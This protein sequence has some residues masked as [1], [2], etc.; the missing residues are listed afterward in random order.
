[1]SRVPLDLCSFSSQG[2]DASTCWGTKASGSLAIR[3][4]RNGR[5]LLALVHEAP[6]AGGL[7]VE[8]AT[9][10]VS[11]MRE[12]ILFHDKRFPGRRVLIVWRLGACTAQTHEQATEKLCPL[13]ILAMQVNASD[14]KHAQHECQAARY[15]RPW[16]DLQLS[17]AEIIIPSWSNF[18]RLALGQKIADR[19]CPSRPV[20]EIRCRSA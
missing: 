15:R 5:K 3:G 12:F 9:K 18:N 17:R 11:W 7:D 6:R 4:N 13:E 1:M 8:T 20:W 16:V 2:C 19:V 10:C 14:R